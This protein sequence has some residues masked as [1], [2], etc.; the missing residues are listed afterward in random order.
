MLLDILD[1]LTADTPSRIQ[2]R[3]RIL[4][5]DGDLAAPDL[6]KIIPVRFRKI[7]TCI[8]DLAACDSP[9]AGQQSE[10]GTEDRRL[11]ASALPDYAHN[12]SGTDPHIESVHCFRISVLY[13]KISDLKH[14]CAPILNLAVRLPA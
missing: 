8:V 3:S 14:S 2:R 7:P 11:S 6:R 13:V 10:N 12:L 9:F 1:K 4:K 5:Y